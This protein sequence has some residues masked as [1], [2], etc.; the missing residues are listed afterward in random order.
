[1]VFVINTLPDYPIITVSRLRLNNAPNVFVYLR[2]LHMFELIWFASY[3][4]SV[5][6]LADLILGHF[7]LGRS[8]VKVLHMAKPKN[9]TT[10][11]LLT[12]VNEVGA[13]CTS[14]IA[15]LGT[16][17]VG[18]RSYYQRHSVG[19][20]DSDF[21]GGGSGSDKDS[22][23]WRNRLFRLNQMRNQETRMTLLGR[24]INCKSHKA[25]AKYRRRQ[26]L[27]YNFLER[28]HGFIATTY[29]VLA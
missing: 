26:T 2:F 19:F 18:D 20:L 23:E 29:H 4:I 11:L 16:S 22:K 8:I 25:D 14:R 3:C 9:S 7:D 28:P 15:A 1:M 12:P 24:P 13:N 10:V 6:S 27:V 17:N 5:R 21:D